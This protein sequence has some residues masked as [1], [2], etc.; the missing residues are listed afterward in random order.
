MILLAWLALGISGQADEPTGTLE[1]RLVVNAADLKKWP[2]NRFYIR[3][4]GTTA[5]AEGVVALRGASLKGLHPPKTPATTVI[6]QRDFQFTPETTALRVGG[7]VKFLNND[8]P[9]HNVRAAHSAAEFSEN[10][11]PDTE[12]VHVFKK[13]TPILDPITLGCIYHGN[14]RAFV[15]VFDHPFFAVTDTPGTFRFEQVPVGEYSLDI[16]HPA[17]RMAKSQRVAI[18]AGATTTVE[19]ELQIP[20]RAK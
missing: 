19:I 17:G 13:P 3:Q 5:V 2:L 20:E 6:D 1:G 9:T 16:N 14:M 10:L 4:K 7:S 8:G 18:K 12:Y 11:T 15:F